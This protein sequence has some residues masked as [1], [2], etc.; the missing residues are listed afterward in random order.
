MTA[1]QPGQEPKDDDQ[2]DE[3]PQD[4]QGNGQQQDTGQG[5]E[6]GGEDTD[7]G[8]DSGDS[9]PSLEAQLE[10]EKRK[11]LKLSKDLG[12]AEAE[13]NKANED[14][15]AAKERDE[16]KAENAKLKGLLEGKFLAWSIETEKKYAWQN[17][18]DVIK[19]ISD[20]EIDINVDKG[21]IEGLDMALKRIA[22]EK[23]YLL[24]QKQDDQQQRPPS[25]SHPVG[26]KSGDTV[27]E[28]H[29]LGKKYKIPGFGTQAQKFM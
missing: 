20:D 10:A 29:R 14:K 7:S 9:G 22:K 6:Q 3:T 12:K 4:Q 24:V 21:Q 13:K 28:Q 8:N 11:N 1:P 17:V 2:G 25:G 5:S 27:T 26:S 18:E 19:F 16:V 23:P 15:D